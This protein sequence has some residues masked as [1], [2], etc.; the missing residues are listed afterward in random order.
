MAEAIKDMFNKL[1]FDRFTKD[2]KLVINDFNT[3]EFLSQV[4]DD[5]WENREFK[6]RCWHIT[7]VLKIFCPQTTKTQ[8]Q[9]YLNY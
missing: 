9:K 3:R 6:Q 4:M 8:S 1:F 7:T 5:E 2:L